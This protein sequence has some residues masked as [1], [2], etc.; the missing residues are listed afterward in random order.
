MFAEMPYKKMEKVNKLGLFAKC[1]CGHEHKFNGNDI[2]LDK[3]DSITA[4]FKTIYT[5][6]DC[7]TKYNGIYENHNVTRDSWHR[8]LSPVGV[9]LSAILVFGL[10]F[11]SVKIIKLF[12]PPPIETDVNKMTNKEYGDFK[13]WEQ[14]QEQKE[15][16][17][18][19]VNNN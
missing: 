17:N 5:C 10:I 8:R 13:K 4:V 19:P 16:E 12:T 15:Q 3:S 6:P 18:L 14:K 2:D 1:D 9:V 7:K 11:G